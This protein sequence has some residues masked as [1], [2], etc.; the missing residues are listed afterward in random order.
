MENNEAPKPP[1][2]GIVYGEIA[3]W[4]LLIGMIIAMVGTVIYMAS[5][6]FVDKTCLL[7]YL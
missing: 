4:L 7:N 3:Y 2:E 5:Q 6:G 1:R